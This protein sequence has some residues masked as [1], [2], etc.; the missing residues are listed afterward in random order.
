MLELTLELLNKRKSALK[1]MLKSA[2]FQYQNTSV[3][4]QMGTHRRSYP[5]T[6]SLI[7]VG[8]LIY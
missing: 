8:K 5:T 6:K 7:L 3:S 1:E 2:S 4:L